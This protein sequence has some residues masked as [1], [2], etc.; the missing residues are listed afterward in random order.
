M[1]AVVKILIVDDQRLVGEGIASLLEKL[2]ERP[3][4]RHAVDLGEA[5]AMAKAFGPD[6]ILMDITTPG[7]NGLEA[8]RQIVREAGS[9]AAVVL[10]STQAESNFVTE[11]LRCGAKGFVLKSAT[12]DELIAAI[13]RVLRGE[14]YISPVIAGDVVER[15]VAGDTNGHEAAPGYTQLSP[16]ERQ[17]LQ[18]LADGLSV[19]EIAHKLALS[20]KTVHAV[21]A[22]LMGKLEIGSI[23]VLTKYAIRHGL[24]PLD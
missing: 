13:R 21:R 20:D 3:G 15:F 8:P 7:L 4:V 14:T 16:R 5:T 22:N 6:L 11:A 23:A 24:T 2:P 18:L 9:D 17:T 12:S 10:L 19:K 1:G